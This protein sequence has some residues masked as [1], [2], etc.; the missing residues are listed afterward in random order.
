M[1]DFQL[2]RNENIFIVFYID[3]LSISKNI[4]KH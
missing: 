3:I 1:L 2:V 4:L